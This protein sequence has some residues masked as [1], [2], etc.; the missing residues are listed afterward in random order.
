MNLKNNT[1][2]N[3]LKEFY[4][5]YIAYKSY[6]YEWNKKQNYVSVFFRNIEYRFKLFK[7][8]R[9]NYTKSYYL[10]E[11]IPFFWF[12]LPGYM[13]EYQ[14]QEGDYVLDCGS[15]HGAFV[16]YASKKVGK[17]GKVFAFEPER[18]NMRILR[19]NL[20]LN[21]CENVILIEKGIWN[22]QDKLNFS[23]TGLGAHLNKEGK[24]LIN[25]TD[26]D[27]ELKNLKI[28]AQKIKFV[29]IDI[30]GAEIEA[31]DGMKNLLKKGSPNLAIASYHWRNNKQTY[32]EVEKKLK[33]LGYITKT[34]Y[35]KHLTTWGSKINIFLNIKS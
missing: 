3:L 23:G 6:S 7:E 16:I 5:K 32:G 12:E 2:Y 35:S 18:G 26:I 24:N 31:I 11:D 27:S 13:K 17:T 34:G 8:K 4:Y 10:A 1:L 33:E 14:L 30:E 25:V 19:E 15:F 9:R 22:K 29:K 21:N 20:K 28:P